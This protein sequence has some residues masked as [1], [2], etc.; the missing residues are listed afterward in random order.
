[1]MIRNLEGIAGA[2]PGWWAD[3]GE[4]NDQGVAERSYRVIAWGY[5]PAEFGEEGDKTVIGLVS[6]SA[7]DGIIDARML[8][9]FIGYSFRQFDG[10]IV[11]IP[12]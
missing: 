4:I 12:V 6:P 11:T 9:D 8:P 3:C 10:P 7:G 2:D 1:M 5:V